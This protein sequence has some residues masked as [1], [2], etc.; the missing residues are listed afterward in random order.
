MSCFQPFSDKFACWILTVLDIAYAC[1]STIYACWST[2]YACWSTIYAC[3]STIYACWNTIYA[4]W[5]TIYSC[6]I[7]KKQSCTWS[8]IH[9]LQAQC[10]HLE[11]QE[12][13]TKPHPGF[14]YFLS[15]A[16]L[17]SDGASMVCQRHCCTCHTFT[18]KCNSKASLVDSGLSSSLWP[19]SNMSY[20]ARLTPPS[21]CGA[22]YN[23]TCR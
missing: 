16:N 12:V 4:C 15:S 6:C 20:Q 13:F 3:W 22:Q 14:D 7:C 11:L 10:R 19:F 8:C 18:W 5:S 17:V 21:G 23:T 1:W 2:I 9:M